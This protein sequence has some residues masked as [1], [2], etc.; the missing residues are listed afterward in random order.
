MTPA[1]QVPIEVA[2]NVRRRWPERAEAWTSR[3]P[4]ELDELVARYEGQAERVFPARTGFVVAVTTPTGP[5]VMRSTADPAGPDQ[6]R[7]AEAFAEHRIGPAVHE[8]NQ[9]DT[10]TWTVA[11]RVVPGEPINLGDDVVPTV[12]PIFRAMAEQP[13]PAPNAPNIA[14]WLHDRLTGP[15]PDDLPPDDYNVTE[16]ERRSAAHQLTDIRQD[17]RRELTHGDAHPDNILV[18]A[19]GRLQW[20]DPRGMNGELAYDLAVF[21][22]KTAPALHCAPHALAD[23]LAAEVGCPADRVH[24][25]LNIAR[26]A[27]V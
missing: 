3:A 25:W 2:V 5:L 24:T 21:A 27:R 12:A 6:A 1:A 14:E 23:Q 10:G 16:D 8:V 20:I 13:S 22:L 26:A 9:T 11:D 15:E 7:F 17:E 18:G 19:D 4:A